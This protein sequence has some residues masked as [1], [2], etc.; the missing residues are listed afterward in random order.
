MTVNAPATLLHIPL[1]VPEPEAMT[2]LVGTVR[3]SDPS[4]N[5]VVPRTCAEFAFQL[6]R[7]W[8][9][10]RLLCNRKNCEDLHFDGIFCGRHGNFA[11]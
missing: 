2:A 11:S 3:L 4:I 6:R 8:C 9:V 5:G 10:C 7:A 1:R